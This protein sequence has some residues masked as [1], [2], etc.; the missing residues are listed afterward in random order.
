MNQQ[1]TNLL[2]AYMCI[3]HRRGAVLDNETKWTL[4][5]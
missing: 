4:Y 1:T 3:V 2:N 5:T